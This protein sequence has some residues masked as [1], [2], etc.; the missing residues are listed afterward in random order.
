MNNEWLATA[1]FHTGCLWNT[2]H[3]ER[4]REYMRTCGLQGVYDGNNVS[5][6]YEK[7]KMEKESFQYHRGHI[8]GKK[9]MSIII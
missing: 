8:V 1:G 9:G 3:E 5:Y 7:G 2:S 6:R 4:Y